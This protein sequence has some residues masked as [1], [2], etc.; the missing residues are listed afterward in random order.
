MKQRQSAL[1]RRVVLADRGC[2]RGTITLVQEDRFRFQDNFGRGYL[3]TLGR[4]N[5]V[6]LR[7]LHTWCD[8]RQTVEV[9]YRGAPDLGAVALRLN[10]TTRHQPA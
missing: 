7:Q 3:F 10:R 9:E 6:S 4:G 8:D 1:T 5:G 2:L